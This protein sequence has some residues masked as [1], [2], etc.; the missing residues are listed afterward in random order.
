M[1]SDL[2]WQ[3]NQHSTARPSCDPRHPTRAVVRSKV[4]ASRFDSWS[5][6][7][8]GGSLFAS[9]SAAGKVWV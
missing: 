6:E 8:H 2:D 5:K 1:Q 9:S 7:N 3:E 4:M